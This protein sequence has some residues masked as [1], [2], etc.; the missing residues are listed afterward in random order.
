MTKVLI[1]VT[2][3]ATLG[4]TDQANGTYAPELTHALHAILAAGFDYDIASI[5]GGEAPL[6]GTD[7]EGDSVNADILADSD[8]QSR[9]NNTIPVSA[10]NI[11]DYDAIFYPGGFGLLS[12]L[13]TNEDF[14]SIAAKHY[15]GGGIISAVC[16]GPGALLP[17]KL[18]NG[19]TLLQSKSVTGFTRE[20]EIDFGTIN[21]I[22]FLLEE[23]L[24]RSAARFNKVQPWQEL[25]I[26][27]ERVIT[28]QNPTSASAVGKALVKLLS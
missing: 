12:D 9:V 18:S 22:P 23:S 26:V 27:D 11:G 16:H 2:N 3:H 13:A 17:I 1:P 25:V 7:I 19:E 20:E 6:Y 24:A 28:G 15:E 8:F 21:D 4:D 5:H 10:V 14:A